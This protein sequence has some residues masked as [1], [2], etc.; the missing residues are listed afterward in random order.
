MAEVY[1]KE[2]GQRVGR[3]LAV[4]RK[5][6]RGPE[7]P[8]QGLPPLKASGPPGSSIARTPHF[9][10]FSESDSFNPSSFGETQDGEWCSHIRGRRLP[11]LYKVQG[12]TARLAWLSRLWDFRCSTGRFQAS[13]GRWSPSYTGTVT[14]PPLPIPCL[15]YFQRGKKPVAW[16]IFRLI[17][18][19]QL[20]QGKM[21]RRNRLRLWPN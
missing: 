12:P 3:N 8:Q 17:C 7:S 18:H 4:A 11:V 2:G 9:V 6:S 16:Q 19:H 21:T 5:S 1:G 10:C 15:L 13:G 20:L 14:S